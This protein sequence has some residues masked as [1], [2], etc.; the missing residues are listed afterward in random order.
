M[1]QAAIQVAK[2]LGLRIFAT[3]GS[4]E[5]RRICQDLGAHH[6]LSSRNLDFADEIMAITEGRGVDA[7]LNSLAGDFIPK[8]L[9][10]LAPFG[11]FLEIGKIDVYKNTRL[12]LEALKNNISFFVIDVLTVNGTAII[13]EIWE[14]LEAGAYRP[15]MHTCFPITEAEEAFRQIA[16]GT[17]IGKNILSFDQPEIPIG[18]CTEDSERFD[19]DAAYLITG[20]AGGFGLELADWM[21]LRG[22]R[23]IALLSR[24][25]P[26]DEEAAAKDREVC[27]WQACKSSICEATWRIWTTSSVA[28]R[29]S[30]QSLP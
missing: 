19:A 2:R 12:G 25:G 23:R 27:G 17:S 7:V 29:K 6:V 22:A 20:G 15:I 21:G 14:L 9:S 8:S 5:K 30:P 26:R 10:V 28:S 11:R 24:S 13:E 4:P 1:G 3:A 18:L 16:Q